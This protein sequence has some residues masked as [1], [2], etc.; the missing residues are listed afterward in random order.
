MELNSRR[1]S[2][3]GAKPGP[4]NQP[5]DIIEQSI[6][7]MMLR[8]AMVRTDLANTIGA[9]SSCAEE[10]KS[11]RRN[12]YQP[13]ASADVAASRSAGRLY[14]ARSMTLLRGKRDSVLASTLWIRLSNSLGQ[15]SS[16]A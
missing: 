8:Q 15:L 1:L 13:W 5:I 6:D 12:G 9:I 3:R 7:F 10:I 2:S 16:N 11:V 14:A 4:H